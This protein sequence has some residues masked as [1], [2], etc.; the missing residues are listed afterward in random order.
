M[1]ACSRCGSGAFRACC[2][3]TRLAFL[4]LGMLIGLFFGAVPGLGGAAALALLTPL[5]YG[6][7]P[8]TALALAGGVMGGV[9]MG[10][11]NTAILL[12]TPGSRPQRR[13]LPSTAILWRSRAR[14]VSPSARRPVPTPSAASSAPY[15]F[16]CRS[17]G[18]ATD[19]PRLRAAGIFPARHLGPSHRLHHFARQ[20]AA[21][22]DHRRARPDDRLHRL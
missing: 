21:R 4:A 18:R 5:T 11:S 6:L 22:P 12:N 7:E 13:H 10:G 14:P 19:R 16:C 9:P 17:A 8:F 1:L 15:R 3:S 2:R 20:I